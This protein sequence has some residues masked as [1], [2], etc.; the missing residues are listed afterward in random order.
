MVALTEEEGVTGA[1]GDVQNAN[2]AVNPEDAFP[3][4]SG[5][6]RWIA[7]MHRVLAGVADITAHPIE[8][9]A[10]RGAEPSI[11]MHHGLLQRIRR[12]EQDLDD[13]GRGGIP[14]PGDVVAVIAVVPLA[15]QVVL[16][17]VGE[18]LDPKVGAPGRKA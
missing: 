18:Q 12:A 6:S 8:T 3:R 17:E 7:R 16:I 9:L 5:K 1:V 10:P 11:G 4:Y 13:M 2:A 14:L 15:V